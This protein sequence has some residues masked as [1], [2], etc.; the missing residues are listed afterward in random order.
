METSFQKFLQKRCLS[1]TN[2]KI[3]LHYGND[4]FLNTF[5]SIYSVSLN[6]YKI[7][8]FL[9][10]NSSSSQYL[11]SLFGALDKISNQRLIISTNA[12]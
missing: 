3:K 8:W 2:M 10:V 1:K 9:N 4:L 12:N 11:N 7:N 5:G 6:D